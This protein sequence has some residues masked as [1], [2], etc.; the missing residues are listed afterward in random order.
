MT[1][2]I[3]TKKE[4]KNTIATIGMIFSI[5]GLILLIS[6]FGA[7]LWVFLLLIWLILWIIWLFYK[8]KKRARIALCIPLIVFIILACVSCYIWSSVKT[9][10]T[11]F[12]S[13][14]KTELENL[15][16]W[17]FNNEDFGNIL[18][19]ELNNIVNDKS[20]DERKSLYESSTGSNNIEKGSY[21]FFSVLKQ[22]FEN[23]LEKY[24]N[25]SL[26]IQDETNDTLDEN[27]NEDQINTEDEE[28]TEEDNTSE[29]KS[30][31]NNEL[32][33]DDIDEILNILE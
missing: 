23:T 7:W 2:E 18:E 27:I 26:E 15:D 25:N 29:E 10:A 12:I 11:E 22:A 14:T 24:N 13:W 8:P 28:K 4:Q 20:K 1:E 32:E 16:D 9:P 3:Q 5:V 30:E 6:I 17:T 31:S 33:Q 19:T 21:L